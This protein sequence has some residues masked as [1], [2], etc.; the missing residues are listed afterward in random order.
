M[1]VHN[2]NWEI[3]M[4]SIVVSEKKTSN[5]KNKAVDEAF[6]YWTTLTALACGS[7]FAARSFIIV[8]LSKS[9]CIV[10]FSFLLPFSQ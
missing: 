8:A 4:K 3:I 6:N 7:A 1:F 2:A 9:P 5:F 10:N